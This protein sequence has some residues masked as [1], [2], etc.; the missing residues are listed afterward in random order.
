MDLVDEENRV[1][2]L[3]E[4]IEDLLDALFEVSAISR[5]GD[6]RAE[7]EGEHT[8]AL[9]HIG[10]LALVNTKREPFGQRRLSDARFTNEQ[11]VV[12]AAPAQ[13]L[14]HPL[15]LERSSDERID[16]SGSRAGDEVR[17]VCLQW[18][19]RRRRLALPSEQRRARLRAV[20]EHAQQK[21]TFDTLRSQEVRG[22][23]VLFLEK[24]DEQAS[25]LD[26]LRARRDGV[27]HR[28]L[29]HAVESER[30]LRL[31]DGRRGDWSERLREHVGQLAAEDVEVSATGCQH[32]PRLRLVGDRQQQVLEPDLLMTTIGGH[33]KGALNR[34]QRFRRERHWCLTHVLVLRLAPWSRA[35]EIPV[36]LPSASSS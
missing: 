36:P 12:L 33:A 22:V 15:D 20:R 7:I 27:H 1:L 34:L 13:H 2:F 26:V 30:R 25:A 11:R 29:N 31:D 5:A 4:S 17:R 32:A 8:R 18:I 19:G 3:Q 14:D 35:E 6:E 10:D 21:Q 24:E 9:Q 16:L 28:L 23:T